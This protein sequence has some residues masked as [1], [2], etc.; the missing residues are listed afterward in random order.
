MVYILNLYEWNIGDL[1]PG[2]LPAAAAVIKLLEKLNDSKDICIK[3]KTQRDKNWHWQEIY[4]YLTLPERRK[5]HITL[6]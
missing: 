4:F 5:D 1:L 6:I 2:G 3:L